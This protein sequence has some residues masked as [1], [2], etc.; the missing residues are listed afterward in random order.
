M[1]MKRKILVFM[2]LVS[3]LSGCA[4]Y[5]T[6]KI[7]SVAEGKTTVAEAF[8]LF[9][10]PYLVVP[11]VTWK[12]FFYE[13]ICVWDHA[14]ADFIDKSGRKI[15]QKGFL[16]ATFDKDGILRLFTVTGTTSDTMID[17]WNTPR[18]QP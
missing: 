8:S 7:H 1:M 4:S 15:P 3:F 13:T 11:H 16:I 14:E 17:Y 6:G 10:K 18:K 9:G 12:S 5:P 2:I